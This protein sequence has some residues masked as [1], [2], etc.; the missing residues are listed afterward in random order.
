MHRIRKDLC[1]DKKCVLELVHG[2]MLMLE[3]EYGSTCFYLLHFAVSFFMVSWVLAAAIQ[4][5]RLD[6]V[7]SSNKMDFEIGWTICA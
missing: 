4:I 2:P 3:Y 1:P 5:R 6:R 7:N